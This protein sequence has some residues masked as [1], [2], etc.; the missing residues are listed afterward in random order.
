MRKCIYKELQREMDNTPRTYGL[1]IGKDSRLKACQDILN[2]WLHG[3]RKYFFLGAKGRKDIIKGKGRSSLSRTSALD[4]CDGLIVGGRRHDGK[5]PML[6]LSFVQR[7]KSDDDLDATVA[8]HIVLV[9]WWSTMHVFFLLSS[10][11]KLKMKLT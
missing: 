7:T 5:G 9:R 3:R 6:F 1:S 4:D 10:R 2:D 11:V 8:A